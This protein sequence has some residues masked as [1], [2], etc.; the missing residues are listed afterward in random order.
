[1]AR[2][3]EVVR[4]SR[5]LTDGQGPSDRLA[6]IASLFTFVSHLV[7]DPCAVSAYP[8]GV[9]ALM[10]LVGPR[11]GPAVALAAMLRA[12]G[13]RVHLDEVAGYC[14]VQV[15]VE[16]ADIDKLPP[17]A[18]LLE[19]R[20]RLYLPLDPRRARAPL[21]FVPLWVRQKVSWREC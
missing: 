10:R 3:P 18:A 13:E 6:R 17:H 20:G 8:D 2:H 9:D 21:G 7:D 4:L 1:M 15:Q 16:A 5:A 14:Y 19:K 11:R 12:T